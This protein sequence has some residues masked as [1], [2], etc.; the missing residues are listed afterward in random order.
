MKIRADALLLLKGL[1]ATREKARAMI[2]AGIVN[3]N[4]IVVK[5]AGEMISEGDVISLRGKPCPYVSRGGLKLESALRY[6]KIDVNGKIC[7][8]IGASTGGFT[9]CLLMNGATKLIA[10][11]VGKNLIDMKLRND[12]RV[13]LIEET[14]ARYLDNIDFQEEV[15]LI[16][17]DVSFISLRLIIPSIKKKCPHTDLLCLFKPQFEVGRKM[18]GRGGIVRNE[19][20]VKESIDGMCKFCEAL[21]YKIAGITPSQVKGQKG[22][23]E[24]F[25]YLKA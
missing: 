20:A 21:D 11:D 6:F 17:A 3:R 24:Y 4:G 15:N 25:I 9:D 19:T 12:P 14:N 22:N 16:V 8:D 5:K 2:M 18:V 1:A 7:L 10:L 23:Q 13:I